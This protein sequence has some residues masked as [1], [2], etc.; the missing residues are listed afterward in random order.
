[1]NHLPILN[2]EPFENGTKVELTHKEN[3]TELAIVVNESLL[4]VVPV[5]QAKSSVSLI[6]IVVSSSISAILLL[7]VLFFSVLICTN[8]ENE[9]YKLLV[10]QGLVER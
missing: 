4:F 2:S 8:K 10:A 7:C 3:M 9:E 5:E 6:G 1:M